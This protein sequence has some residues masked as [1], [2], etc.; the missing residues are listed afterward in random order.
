VSQNLDHIWAGWR[1]AYVSGDSDTRPVPPGEGSIFERILQS[2]LNNRESYV[3]W[4]GQHC[5]ALLNAYP[6]GTG[7][8]LVMPKRAVPDLVS[9]SAE[10]HQELW[11]GVRL[12]VRAITDAYQPHGINVG[13]NIGVAGG[14]SV[15]DHLHVHCLPRW[16]GDTTFLTTI[17]ETRMIPEPLDLTWEKLSAAWPT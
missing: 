11:E 10:A 14:A 1:S 12:T 4:R 5:A 6:Y 9:L 13:A 7:H 16:G 2:G 15:P 3:L 8:V 17:A